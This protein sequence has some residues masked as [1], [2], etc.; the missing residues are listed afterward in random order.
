MQVRTRPTFSGG[1]EPRLLQDADMLLHAREGHAERLG[2]L[3]DRSVRTSELLQNTAPGGVRER[4]ER[5]VEAGCRILN[6]MVQY[7]AQQL[8]ARKWAE[9]AELRL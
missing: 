7:L 1:D 3:R 4:G 6:H 8:L 2:K 9:R 5:G